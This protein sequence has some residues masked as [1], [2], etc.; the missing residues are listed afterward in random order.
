M[1]PQQLKEQI[2]EMIKPTFIPNIYA[3]PSEHKIASNQ[4]YQNGSLFGID[5]SSAAV[6]EALG[7]NAADTRIL[8]ICCAPGAK[9]TFI[10]DKLRVLTERDN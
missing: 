9:L 10:A 6:V 4:L 8:E 5:Y 1:N 3:I 7:L 2:S